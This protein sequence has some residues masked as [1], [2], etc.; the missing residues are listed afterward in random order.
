MLAAVSTRVVGLLRENFGRGPLPAKSY[1]MDDCII[2]VL[3]TAITAASRR[4]PR[5]ARWAA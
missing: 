3:P 5:A 4:S 1:A 2:C